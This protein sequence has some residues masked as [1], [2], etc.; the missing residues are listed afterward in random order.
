M[1]ALFVSGLVLGS[2]AW[3]LSAVAMGF[4]TGSFWMGALG[5]AAYAG[6]GMFIGLHLIYRLGRHRGTCKK[7]S[8]DCFICYEPSTSY[9][10]VATSF[11]NWPVVILV[12]VL[13]G[14][15]IWIIGPIVTSIAKLYEKIFDTAKRDV[16]AALEKTKGPGEP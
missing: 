5:A 6:I 2:I 8:Y 7:G 4:K 9:Q 13:G 11:I 12:S 15:G 1:D 16:K 3:I 10:V 14:I